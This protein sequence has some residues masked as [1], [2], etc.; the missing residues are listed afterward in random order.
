[1]SAYIIEIHIYVAKEHRHGV[2]TRLTI[3]QIRHFIK[4][5]SEFL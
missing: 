1:M 4:T 3:L 5:I 2:L